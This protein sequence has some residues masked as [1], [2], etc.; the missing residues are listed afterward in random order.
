MTDDDDLDFVTAFEEWR[1]RF[2]ALPDDQKRAVAERLL[3]ELVEI[4]LN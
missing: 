1:V 2:D 3:A 4:H